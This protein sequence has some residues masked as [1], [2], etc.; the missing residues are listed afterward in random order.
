MFNGS[1]VTG[2]FAD[3]KQQA[4]V[5]WLAQHPEYN[6]ADLTW[7]PDAAPDADGTSLLYYSA[8]HDTRHTGLVITAVTVE[9]NQAHL[10]PEQ[11]LPWVW[12]WEAP[13]GR[14]SRNPYVNIRLAR[15]DAEGDYRRRNRQHNASLRWTAAQPGDETDDPDDKFV[16]QMTAD[17][18]RVP[19]F[20][21]RRSIVFAISD[22]YEIPEEIKDMFDQLAGKVHSEDGEIMRSL[23][24]LLQRHEQVVLA[25]ASKEANE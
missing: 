3:A 5:H 17:G 2:S 9:V 12:E 8:D 14:T 21:C 13:D 11:V 7:R 6:D 4:E 25:N 24:R 22:A 15:H 23:R 18:A 20:L 10:K 1:G 19:Y 16:L